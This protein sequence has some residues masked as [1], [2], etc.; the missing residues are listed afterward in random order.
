MD[1]QSRIK[2]LGVVKMPVLLIIKVIFHA[3]NIY[4]AKV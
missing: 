3:S 1:S 2:L 4:Y